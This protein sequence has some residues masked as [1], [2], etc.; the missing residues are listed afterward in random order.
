MNIIQNLKT[1]RST[2]PGTFY[3]TSMAK[4][5]RNTG[6]SMAITRNVYTIVNVYPF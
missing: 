1:Y 2:V 3:S 4:I 5:H 6:T